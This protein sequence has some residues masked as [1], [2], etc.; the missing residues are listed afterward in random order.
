MQSFFKW[1]C[2]V[3]SVVEMPYIAHLM[4]TLDFGVHAAELFHKN[5]LIG[6]FDIN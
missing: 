5:V 3:S 1:I 2:T 6:C 4:N